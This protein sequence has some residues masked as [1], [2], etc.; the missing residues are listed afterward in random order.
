MSH[1]PEVENLSE[2]CGTEKPCCL[3]PSG[4]LSK[5]ILT[6]ILASEEII[7]QGQSLPAALYPSVHESAVSGP[8]IP[9]LWPVT[10]LPGRQ[11]EA[12]EK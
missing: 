2:R 12:T 4:L 7:M 3:P 8:S 10:I 11:A 9:L 1:F 6:S 5:K